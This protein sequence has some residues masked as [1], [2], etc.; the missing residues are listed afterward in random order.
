MF[1]TIQSPGVIAHTLGGK[2]AFGEL[3]GSVRPRT[4]GLPILV[5]V[6]ASN[7]LSARLNAEAEFRQRALH[8]G[9]PRRL[10]PAAVALA[11]FELH[12]TTNGIV[13]EPAGD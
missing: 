4:E 5:I 10:S 3:D 8:I 7:A 9:A 13:L 1:S 2:I 6:D 12:V 11:E